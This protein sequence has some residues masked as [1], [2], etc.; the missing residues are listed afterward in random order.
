MSTHVVVVVP[1]IQRDHW[2]GEEYQSTAEFRLNPYE[3]EQIVRSIQAQ[4]P[5][6]KKQIEEEKARRIIEVERELKSLKGGA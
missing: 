2:S 3:A 4:L 1:C 5:S 6:V